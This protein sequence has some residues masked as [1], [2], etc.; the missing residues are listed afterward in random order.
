M[1]LNISVDVDG[2]ILD[3]NEN[4]VPQVRESIQRLKDAGHY[5]QLWSGGGAEY[6]EKIARK[7]SLTH[8]IDSYAKKADIAIDDLPET[9][10]PLSVIHVDQ[11]HTFE[12]AVQKI[13]S[14]EQNVEAA[15]TLNSGL[16]SFVKDLQAEK[17]DFQNQYKPILRKGIPLHPVPF[18]GVVE[19]A[20]AITVGLNPSTTEFESWPSVLTACELTKRL[21][22]YFQ[23]S[24]NTPHYWFAE[25]QW[26]FE[27]LHCPY[28][29]AAAHIDVTPWTTYSPTTLAAE[30]R[31]L[32]LNQRLL[33]LYNQLLDAGVQDHLP[34]VLKFCKDTVKLIIICSSDEPRR[35]EAQRLPKIEQAIRHS[36]SEGWNG[37]IVIKPK[38]QIS[39]W[40]WENR[41]EL[42]RLLDV[43]HFFP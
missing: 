16:V 15:L 20:R 38:S 40:A 17:E 18:F 19:N 34:R 7:F 1:P 25:L 13:F 3:E 22:D 28:H 39:R 2:T 33:P 24:K 27:A 30:D 29:F 4:L 36:L 6:A 43:E 10:H 23:L 14:V 8:L 5:V 32:P 12:Q 42:V 9:A 41:S 31:N 26:A 11:E 35:E 21:V 37:E